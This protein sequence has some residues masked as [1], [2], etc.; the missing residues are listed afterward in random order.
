MFSIVHRG[1]KS[2]FGPIK[3]SVISTTS[4]R[5]DITRQFIRQIFQDTYNASIEPRPD[6]FVICE[7]NTAGNC[8]PLACAGL[9]FGFAR[10]RLFS[11][12]YLDDAIEVALDRT[13]K[14]AVERTEIVEIGSL[15]SRHAAAAADLIRVLP[16]IAWFLGMRAILCTTTADLR[17]LL[18]YHHIP[19][20]ALTE[21]SS[22]RL[23]ESEHERWGSYYENSPLTGIIPLQECG[24]LFSSHCGRF[25]FANL[26]GA[27][28]ES[29][30]SNPAQQDAVA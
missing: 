20:V 10:N 16:I 8:I 3:S 1:T 12:Q 5:S 25:V 19:F 28:T 30:T 22:A 15:A 11:E 9:T 23:S 27:G 29:A 14:H 13:G 2:K 24:H 26:S 4:P 18:D 21:A 7:R 6:A 17:K